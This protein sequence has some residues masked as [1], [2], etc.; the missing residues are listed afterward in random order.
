[1][2]KYFVKKA[3]INHD[4]IYHSTAQNPKTTKRPTYVCKFMSQG[5]CLCKSHCDQTYAKLAIKGICY[6][7]NKYILSYTFTLPHVVTEKC[8]NKVPHRSKQNARLHRYEVI[9]LLL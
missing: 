4:I 7:V 2:T 8:K 6:P 1:M 3:N 9:C 5:L